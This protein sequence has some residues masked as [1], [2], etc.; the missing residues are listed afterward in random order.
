MDA[1]MLDVTMGIGS[2]AV[3]IVALIALPKLVPAS[4]KGVAYII[5]IV[6]YIALMTG[7]GILIGEKIA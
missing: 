5:A 3:F 6:I 1:R 7:T 4:L 2:L